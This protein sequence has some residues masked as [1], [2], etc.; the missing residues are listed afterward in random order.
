MTV[1]HFEITKVI[2]LFY[3]FIKLSRKSKHFYETG[4]KKKGSLWWKNIW[5]RYLN[6]NWTLCNAT[7]HSIYL[8]KG[9]FHS[10]CLVRFL[11]YYFQERHEIYCPVLCKNEVWAETFFFFFFIVPA[12]HVKLYT[13]KKDFLAKTRLHILPVSWFYFH[14]FCV[15]TRI[16]CLFFETITGFI[17]HG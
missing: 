7:F 5:E 10:M 15:K 8:V 6:R 1:A 13:Q 11:H 9:T 4:H 12:F 16:F 2:T 3:F 17:I 14:F